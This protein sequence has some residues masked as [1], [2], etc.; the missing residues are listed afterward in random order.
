MPVETYS[1]WH[2]D[3]EGMWE[4]CR[5]A[6][7][8]SEAI[9]ASTA[10]FL[11]Q[12][13]GMED[14]EFTDYVA[15]ALYLNA[16]QRTHDGLIGMVMGKPAQEDIP[17]GLREAV[18]YIDGRGSRLED[19][20][21][22]AVSEV[23]EV[24]GGLSV[25]D[26]PERPE[27]IVTAAQER[28]A[29]LRPRAMWYPIE[30]VMEYRLGVVLGNQEITFLKLWETYTAAEDEWTVNVH[31]QI[32]VYDMEE[33]R[34]RVRIF[35]KAA[36]GKWEQFTEAHPTGRNGVGLTYIP[37]VFFGPIRNMPGKPP[38][39][40]LVDVNFAHYR[41]SA[42]LEHAL[43]FTGLPTAYASGVAPDS[44]AGGL[45]LGSSMG[46][47]F[48]DP[49]A[50]IQYATYGADGLGALKEAM[51]DK[52]QAMAA[53]G[54]RMLAPDMRAAES[55][56]ALAIRRT[57][58]NSALAK[59]AD[60]V[61]RSVVLVLETMAEWMGVTGDISYSLNT[62][63]LPNSIDA[64]EITALVG[65]WQNGA[66]TSPEL[67]DRFKHGGVVRDDK[68][69][70]EHEAELLLADEARLTDQAAALT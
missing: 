57:G 60:S 53:L 8:G 47:V 7:A 65:A 34:V 10:T 55:G 62:E 58:E 40:D 31:P 5:A 3:N 9:K 1:K 29:G 16:T 45:R 41:N 20:A 69:F 61:S 32:R 22:N 12:P 44:V 68:T 35:R 6:V 63:Y 59:L 52:V 46:Y 38:L 70:E 43:H 11:P 54:A 27:G 14:A 13:S 66:L 28:A 15:R 21:R 33:G 23:L 30:S 2:T 56:E 67:F 51:S 48:E 24:G 39:S 4:R 64:N 26:H 42:D 19:F 17:P 36:S 50:S 37:A 25:V 49:N 18:D